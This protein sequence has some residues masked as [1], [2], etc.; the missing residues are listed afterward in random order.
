MSHVTGNVTTRNAPIVGLS[1]TVDVPF[2]LPANT[3]P[4]DVDLASAKVS[5]NGN[6]LLPADYELTVIA[7]GPTGNQFHVVNRLSYPFPPVSSVVIEA[8]I[9]VPPYVGMSPSEM[10]DTLIDHEARLP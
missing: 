1:G 5:L 6:V 2:I 9:T 8:P 3:L 4:A 7:G 10:A